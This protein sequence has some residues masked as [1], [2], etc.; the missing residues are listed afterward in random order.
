MASVVS[1]VASSADFATSTRAADHKGTTMG[2]V[3]ERHA[4]WEI[5]CRRKGDKP[6]DVCAA[7]QSV[8]AAD[9]KDFRITVYFQQFKDGQRLLRVYTPRGL[10]LPPGVGLKID[11]KDRG[12]APFLKCE[13]H[14][15]ACYAHI[16]VDDQ[17]LDRLKSGTS[18]IFI[19][20]ENEEKG[21]GVPVTLTGF[22][23]AVRALDRR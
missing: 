13:K 4:N 19:V 22:A 16:Q 1:I 15:D 5:V 12:H 9:K 6:G 20:F 11:D 17:L 3:R 10:L 23:D 14:V 21:L 18:A 2:K 8:E 7:V